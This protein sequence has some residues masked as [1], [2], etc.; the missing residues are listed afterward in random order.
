MRSLLNKLFKGTPKEELA[1][2]AEGHVSHEHLSVWANTRYGM[3]M[4]RISHS[5]LYRPYTDAKH[6]FGFY[7]NR[8]IIGE[9]TRILGGIYVS[10][11]PAEAIVV[12]ECYEMLRPI[13]ASFR[14]R[15]ENQPSGAIEQELTLLEEVFNLADSAFRW[16]PDEIEAFNREHNIM[17]D[18]KVALDL[19]IKEKIGVSRH[20]VL[21]AA[22]IIEKLREDGRL[23]GM[24]TIP[25]QMRDNGGNDEIL[26]YTFQNGAFA[27]FD[28][29]PSSDVVFPLPHVINA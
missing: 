19:Y 20:K 4:N 5:P 27:T 15:T 7:H 26:T 24:Q 2:R 18:T 6:P 14:T 17:P 22:Y 28:P 25:G 8:P 29:T 10:A 23:T 16:A 9:G 21:L 11:Q 3:A 12:D 13:I 1:S